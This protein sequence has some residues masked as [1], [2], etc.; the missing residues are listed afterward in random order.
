MSASPRVSVIMPFLNP[1]NYIREAIESVLVQTYSDWELLLIDDGSTDT[2]TSIALEYASQ[3]PGKIHYFSHESHQNLGMSVSRNL[4]IYHSHGEYITFLDADDV[5]LP[6][7]LK[8]QVSILDSQPD[9]GMIFGGTVWWYSWTGKEADLN[10]DF[11]IDSFGV[12]PNSV[13]YPPAFFPFM[14]RDGL[15]P[16]ICSFLVRREVAIKIGGFEDDF[17]KIYSDQPFLVKLCLSTPIFFYHGCFEKYRQHPESFCTVGN[18]PDKAIPNRLQFLNWVEQYIKSQ[19]IQDQNVWEIID[20]ELWMYHHQD[21][22]WTIKNIKNIV[23]HGKYIFKRVCI[24]LNR[25]LPRKS[26]GSLSATPNPNYMPRERYIP[27]KITWSARGTE[28]V[29]VRLGSPKGLLIVHSSS[30][31]GSID[32]I[33][34]FNGMLYFLQDVSGGKDL[35]ETNTLDILKIQVRIT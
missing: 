30:Y 12:N 3:F 5:Y 6:E 1:G 8:I 10:R 29:E 16:C 9:A 17:K 14:I 32:C 24:K 21:N 20:E 22:T 31:G 4:G 13:I 18:K 27:T 35:N 25:R 19:N 34:I 11:P 26:S 15:C 2:S 7:K 23:R 33:C 28:E